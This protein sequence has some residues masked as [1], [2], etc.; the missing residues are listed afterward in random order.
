MFNP[1]TRDTQR[2]FSKIK[3]FWAWADKL[4]G[5]FMRHLGYF[6]P[7]YKHF[8]LALWV[9]CPWESVAGS[10][11]YKKL[12]FLGLK[13]TTPKYSQNKIWAIKNLGNNV[14]TSVFGVWSYLPLSKY[15]IKWK[16]TPN[17]CG[18]LRK[19][20]LYLKLQVPLRSSEVF[21]QMHRYFFKLFPKS[22]LMI[23]GWHF[24]VVLL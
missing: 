8:F 23:G 10:L 4:C 2:A 13:H 15:Q 3:N 14:R 19:A 6:W 24:I 20:E 1:Q 12:W 18:L 16:V 9:P 21:Q 11:S 5:N 17:F 22:N 7:I